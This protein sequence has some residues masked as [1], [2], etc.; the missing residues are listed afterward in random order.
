M[1]P[2]SSQGL[3]A[4]QAQGA[5]KS[6]A[7][8]GNGGVLMNPWPKGEKGAGPFMQPKGVANGESGF[9]PIRVRIP[10]SLSQTSRPGDNS[11]EMQRYVHCRDAMFLD[12]VVAS[13]HDFTRHRRLRARLSK[14][15]RV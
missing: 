5:M 4:I 10:P 9:S 12:E 15:I 7:F 8:P 11:H 6:P 3:D 14:T 2:G 13:S 1:V